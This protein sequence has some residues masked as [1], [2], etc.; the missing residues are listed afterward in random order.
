MLCA[1]IH[2]QFAVMAKTDDAT[3]AAILPPK[4]KARQLRRKLG[5]ATAK[6]LPDLCGTHTVVLP[7]STLGPHYK[8]IRMEIRDGYGFVMHLLCDASLRHAASYICY[9]AL[10][11]FL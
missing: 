1:C 2:V 7:Y 10:L 3:R 4:T 8:D 11:S 5:V 9:G 6:L